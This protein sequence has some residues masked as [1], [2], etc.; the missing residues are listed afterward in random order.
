MAV[1]GR[2]GAE[3]IVA[4]EYGS[5]YVI[6]AIADAD[7]ATKRLNVTLSGID[8]VGSFTLPRSYRVYDGDTAYAMELAAVVGLGVL[9]GR[10]KAHKLPAAGG[11]WACAGLLLLHRGGRWRAGLHAA[12]FQ[13][14]S[15]WSEM[16][17]QLLGLPG[18]EDVRIEAESA[19]GA[20]L[21]LALSRWRRRAGLRPLR[22]W[23]RAREW[24][25]PAHT[26]FGLLGPILGHLSQACRQRSGDKRRN[27]AAAAAARRARDERD[28]DR[29][30]NLPNLI[31]L[32]RVIL[33]PV[34]FWLLITG[35]TQ[36][37]FVLFIVAGI[38]DA[39]DGYLAKTFGWQ[40]ELGAYLDLLADKLLIVCI[41]LALGVDGNLP[42]WLVV[43]VVSRDILIVIAVHPVRELRLV[44]LVVLV[45]VE[46]AH[47]LLLGLAGRDR[48]QRR[49]AEERHLDVVG[50]AMEAEEPAVALDAVEGR[51]PFHRLAHAGD[52]ARD[53]RVEAAPDV[54]L[55]ARHGGD[56]RLH[57]GVAIALGDLR[58]AAGE[59]RFGP[60]GRALR[61]LARLGRLRGGFFGGRGFA[62]LCLSALFAMQSLSALL[63]ASNLVQ[64]V[65]E[66]L[67]AGL[68]AAEGLLLTRP[69]ARLLHAQVGA[70]AVGVSVNVTTLFRA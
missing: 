67:P 32:L 43:A 60:C 26:S 57:R 4:G 42:V 12:Q 8:A 37:A 18:V 9:E 6:L 29:A 20:D 56:V 36:L 17:R 61:G 66:L 54:A 5:P 50:E 41:F 59:K 3:R 25:R 7:A 15:E 58:V 46:V 48:T 19:R 38:S 53:E 47:V 62:G 27:T 14:L 49:A 68:G 24:R 63:R 55:P 28:V 39:V 69:E 40:T 13:S 2:G 35:Q 31:T 51:V 30:L 11:S 1:E 52:G 33:V 65:E 64:L 16:R 34:V 10:W 21:R 70:G 44:E 22:P 45:D 23:P